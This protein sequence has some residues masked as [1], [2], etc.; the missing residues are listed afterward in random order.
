M[1]N[2]TVKAGDTLESISE[3]VYGTPDSAELIRVANPQ[4]DG[5]IAVGMPLIIPE[6]TFGV[7]PQQHAGQGDPGEVTIKIDGTTFRFW[8][9]I[10]IVRSI[11]SLD[12]VSMSA[13]FE[14]KHHR[15]RELFLPFA[16]KPLEILVGGKI[17]F[18]GTLVNSTPNIA[19]DAR[20]VVA[21]CYARAGVLYDVTMPPPQGSRGLEYRDLDLQ[22]ITT[23]MGEPFAIVPVFDGLSSED[24]GPV[25]R[26]TSI[27]PVQKVLPYWTKL[28]RQR[29]L[30]IG[31]DVFGQPVF[32]KGSDAPPVE[33]LEEGVSPLLSITP[34]FSPQKYWSHITAIAPTKIGVGSS[35]FTEPN[36][37]LT[38][39]LRPLVFRVEDV[40]GAE[41][42]KAAQSKMGRMFANSMQWV[43]AVAGWHTSSG[44][45]WNPNT[46][47]KV[48]AHGAFIYQ[49]TKFLIRS[50]DQRQAADNL[51]TRL[52]IVP[53]GSYSGDVSN[54]LPWGKPWE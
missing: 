22:G 19:V 50:V 16:Y 6:K 48:H 36:P 11:D 54:R 47:V 44:K 42:K 37:H 7:S 30:V 20:T 46:T 17:L 28:A 9:G 23:A 29:G 40:L 8:D 5:G 14:P 2:H 12:R 4:A 41:S 33:S 51:T 38:D 24:I 3:Q 1:S 35:R 15:F 18:T 31:N 25:I 43:V 21:N 32:Q 26:R 34:Q 27:D 45:L 52:T 13:P 53:L 49:P 10:D 39:V